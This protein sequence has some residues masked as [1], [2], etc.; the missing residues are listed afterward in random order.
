MIVKYLCN[1]HLHSKHFLNVLECI[2]HQDCTGLSDTCTS[3]T[4]KCG[5]NPSCSGLTSDTCENGFCKCGL[6]ASC[7][8]NGIMCISGACIGRYWTFLKWLLRIIQKNVIL[9][10]EMT[11]AIWY[12]SFLQKLW[13][14]FVI[15][16]PVQMEESAMSVTAHV[17]VQVGVLGARV[18][19]ARVCS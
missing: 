14:I 11:T 9:R 12:K 5:V 16:V 18:K 17:S 2:H 4:C 1:V 3:K 8:G 7:T 10:N 15:P 13:K 6:D 19:I